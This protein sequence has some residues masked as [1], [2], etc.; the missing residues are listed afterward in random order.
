MPFVRQWAQ[1]EWRPAAVEWLSMPR[2]GRSIKEHIMYTRIV[3][4]L[5]G[6]D[7]AE[8][9]LATA[10]DLA[11]TT[12]G[13]MHLIRVVDFPSSSFTYVYGSMIESQA[14][15]MQLEDERALADSYLQEV[16]RSIESRGI[17]VTTETRHGVAIQELI[18]AMQP[19]DLFVVASHGRSGVARWFLGSVA[20]EIMRRATVPVLLVRAQS[21]SARRRP[22][23]STSL[24]A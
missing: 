14:I 8:Q 11:R 18:D 20:E 17:H 23:R 24:S 10:E 15:A 16:A 5:D 3:V 2:I 6:S 21:A 12:G 13:S 4:P 1:H 9:A 19:G 22:Q 7:L